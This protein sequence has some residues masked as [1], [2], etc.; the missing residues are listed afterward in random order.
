MA[1]RTSRRRNMNRGYQ[2]LTVWQDARTLYA[3]T[4]RIFRGF[5]YVLG[6]VAANQIAS[7]DSVHRNIADQVSH[8]DFEEWDALAYKLE[9]GLKRLIESLQ[10]KRLEGDWEDTFVIRESN[11]VYNVA[12]PPNEDDENP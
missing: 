9:N 1:E 11:A 10:R 12:E 2:K 8:G 6:R 3:L 5:P 4:C 7:V